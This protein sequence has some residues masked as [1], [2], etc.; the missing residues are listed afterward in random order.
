MKPVDRF[1]VIIER[2]NRP[3]WGKAE[4]KSDSGIADTGECKAPVARPGTDSRPASGNSQFNSQK[5]S[6]IKQQ[7]ASGHYHV[8]TDALAVKMLDTAT[9]GRRARKATR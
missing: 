4:A 7:I 8:D 6:R 1:S 3:V 2:L 9:L 5:V